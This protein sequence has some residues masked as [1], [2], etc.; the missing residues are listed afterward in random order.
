MRV[1]PFMLQGMFLKRQH[2][3]SAEFADCMTEKL[4]SSE[5]LWHN[6]LTGTGATLFAELLQRRT[7]TFMAGTA[8]VLYGGT[9]PTEFAGRTY[10]SDFETRVSSRVLELLPQELPRVHPYVDGALQLRP[11]LKDN[12]RKLTPQQ[13]EQLLHPVFQEDELTLILVG[14]ILGLI[15]GYGQ[16]VWDAR[17]KAAQAETDAGSE[18]RRGEG[19]ADAA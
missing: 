9:V 10:W 11:T 15:V 7:A 18:Q 6:I 2:E 1:G 16:A 4:L 5:T 17:S 19:G 8:A 3:V 14:A 13:F 12:L